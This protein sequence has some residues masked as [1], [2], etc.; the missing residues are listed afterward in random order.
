MRV[1]VK[2]KK[3]CTAK[4][5]VYTCGQCSVTYMTLRKAAKVAKKSFHDFKSP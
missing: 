3:N 4:K 2:S 5:E 1:R